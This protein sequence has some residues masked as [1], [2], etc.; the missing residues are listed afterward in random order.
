MSK[1]YRIEFVCQ[2]FPEQTVPVGA[3][4]PTNACQALW[5]YYITMQA[6]LREYRKPRL[7]GDKFELQPQ[8]TMRGVAK[9]YNVT[10]D[11]M[12]RYWPLVDMQCD[13]MLQ[14]R[15][16]PEY[17]FDK[18]VIIVTQAGGSAM[19]KKELP[20]APLIFAASKLPA[21][22]DKDS[23]AGHLFTMRNKIN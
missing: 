14:R 6:L 18:P 23:T 12:I 17:R 5:R 2:M 4:A 15:M 13:L 19:Q 8:K 16:E 21:V 20:T 3:L 11:E 22:D 7:E 9:L 10:P 1:R